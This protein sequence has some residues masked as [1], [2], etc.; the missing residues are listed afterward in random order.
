M[1]LSSNFVEGRSEI[2]RIP[3]DEAMEISYS[4]RMTAVRRWLKCLASWSGEARWQI[5]IKCVSSLHGG[6]YTL[7]ARHHECAKLFATINIKKEMS[8]ATCFRAPMLWDERRIYWYE[9]YSRRHYNTWRYSRRAWSAHQ[10]KRKYL[11]RRKNAV[12]A[13]AHLMIYSNDARGFD[14]MRWWARCGICAYERSAGA[15]AW[16]KPALRLM[17]SRN[18]NSY[19]ISD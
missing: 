13:M 16:R 8:R 3:L 14:R 7:N 17:V 5:A 12:V 11:A 1:A 19:V 18:L 4:W 6:D 15:N 9:R 10:W 2:K